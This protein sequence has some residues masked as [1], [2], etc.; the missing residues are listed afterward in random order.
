M[1]QNLNI[2]WWK[3]KLFLI[4]HF[5]KHD[6]MPLHRLETRK[7]QAWIM[8]T[9][10]HNTDAPKKEFFPMYSP[11]LYGASAT[12]LGP[13]PYCLFFVSNQEARESVFHQQIIFVWML[14]WQ[15]KC[16]LLHKSF[17][18]LHSEFISPLWPVLRPVE[19]TSQWL[20]LVREQLWD[21]WCY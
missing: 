10:I 17:S 16:N 9:H 1:R 8:E 6:T 21:I 14:Q 12:A 3:K 15:K 13:S 19:I 18:M 11:A 7:P 2:C 20:Y 4:F 5:N